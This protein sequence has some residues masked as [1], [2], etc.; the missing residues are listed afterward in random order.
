VG[1]F[2]LCCI[3]VGGFVLFGEPIEWKN[4]T[5]VLITLSG[6]FLYT[7][8]KLEEGERTKRAQEVPPPAP[9]SGR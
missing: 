3:I 5:G 9:A 1:H 8:Y 6:I 4:L 7:H 2:K